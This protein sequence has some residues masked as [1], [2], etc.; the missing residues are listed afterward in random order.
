M[1]HVVSDRVTKTS[2][3]SSDTLWTLCLMPLEYHLKVRTS[4]LG[5]GAL[6]RPSPS[7]SVILYL[8]LGQMMHSFLS[9]SCMRQQMTVINNEEPNN[10]V[11][12]AR[13]VSTKYTSIVLFLNRHY[14]F[15]QSAYIVF[16]HTVT[17][18][19]V[20]V[21]IVMSQGGSGPLPLA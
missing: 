19:V 16:M 11:R 3:P 2:P 4:W 21:Y 1:K 10:T 14:I 9:M 20:N 12:S 5:T 7:A 17:N 13:L 8:C 18:S 15:I 6:K